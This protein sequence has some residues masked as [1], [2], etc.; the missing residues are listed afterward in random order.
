MRDRTPDQDQDQDQD[1]DRLPAGTAGQ[2]AA[3]VSSSI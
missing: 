1:Q 3:R 2:E